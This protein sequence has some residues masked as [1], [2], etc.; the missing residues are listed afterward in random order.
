MQRWPDAFML[1]ARYAVG[2]KEF[3]RISLVWGKILG[4]WT[5]F[6]PLGCTISFFISFL[7]TYPHRYLHVSFVLSPS[8][9]SMPRYTL[10]WTYLDALFFFITMYCL[11]V[12]AWL[13]IRQ[14]V[15]LI[16]TKVSGAVMG[17][18]QT[19][20]FFCTANK[21]ATKQNSQVLRSPG[22]SRHPY[23]KSW[24][25]ILLTTRFSCL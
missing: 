21:P 8:K 7:Y 1:V 24:F 25:E 13:E 23:G 11:L 20:F 9:C 14:P 22:H 18:S 12:D 5:L 2:G 17:R 16:D 15:Y 10:Y 6:V 4:K 3:K 19:L